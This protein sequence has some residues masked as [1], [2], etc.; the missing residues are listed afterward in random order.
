MCAE[1]LTHP[2]SPSA[3]LSLPPPLSLSLSLALSLSLS[4][5]VCD[6]LVCVCVFVYMCMCRNVALDL[7]SLTI[8]CVLLLQ[9]VFSYYRMYGVYAQIKEIKRKCGS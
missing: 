9:N 6:V 5:C 2:I 1:C 4:E 8:E 3:R 7:R